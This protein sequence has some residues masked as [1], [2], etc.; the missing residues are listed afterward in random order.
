MP[1]A[2]ISIGSNIDPDRNVREAIHLIERY[3]PVI[4]ISTVYSTEAE[5]RTE[6]P[7]YYNCVIKIETEISPME[8]KYRVLRTIEKELGRQRTSDKYAPRT[9]DLDLI[10]YDE[11][12]LRT[13]ELNLPDLQML[14]RSFVAVPLLELEP[15]LTIPGIELNKEDAA[16]L[17]SQD[18]MKP[19][20]D[21]TMRLREE[22]AYGRKHGK[23]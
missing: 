13:D 9:I 12:V 22:T 10:V 23:D 14:H 17:L 3:A 8:L 1:R 2:F 5:G 15:G 7:R 16:A 20:S 6:Q 21:Y 11:L 4:G 18:G 19:L